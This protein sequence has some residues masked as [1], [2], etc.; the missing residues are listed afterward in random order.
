[1]HVLII[2]FREKP[3]ISQRFY[4]WTQQHL[5]RNKPLFKSLSFSRICSFYLISDVIIQNAIS[6]VQ[7]LDF[8]IYKENSAVRIP[9]NFT[10]APQT[11][12]LQRL[13][14]PRT[15]IPLLRAQTNFSCFQSLSLPEPAAAIKDIH[16]STQDDYDW[17][18]HQTINLFPSLT[19]SPPSHLSVPLLFV[20]SAPFS[21]CFVDVQNMMKKRERRRLWHG[22]TWE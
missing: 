7:K 18:I 14:A 11:N 10:P 17:S 21:R 22:G 5:S 8:Y 16:P 6:I 3:A 2:F 1:M 9:S 20:S 13:H 15:L 12:P 19:S 4:W